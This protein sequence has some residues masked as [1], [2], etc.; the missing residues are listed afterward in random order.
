MQQPKF[1]TA[2]ENYWTNSRKDKPTE[3]NKQPPS[4]KT[5]E[6]GKCI[7]AKYHYTLVLILLLSHILAFGHYQAFWGG[8]GFGRTKCSCV[9]I[10]LK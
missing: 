9:F 6:N 10:F 2:S 4:S 7:W 8:Y 1:F 3:G 5:A